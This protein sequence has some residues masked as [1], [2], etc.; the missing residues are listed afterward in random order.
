MRVRSPSHER[1]SVCFI[2]R[3]RTYLLLSSRG[4]IRIRSRGCENL[5][6]SDTW[7]WKVQPKINTVEGASDLHVNADG[8]IYKIVNRKVGLESCR[9]LEKSPILKLSDNGLRSRR[10]SCN[11]EIESGAG[12]IF[13]TKGRKN[14]SQRGVPINF[15]FYFLSIFLN[16]YGFHSEI[17]VWKSRI[18]QV[19]S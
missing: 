1:D 10:C 9:N 14:V 5:T 3:K 16:T 11:G 7:F 18:I 19:G 6:T 13:Q 12:G 4:D 2:E 15:L 17:V 8:F